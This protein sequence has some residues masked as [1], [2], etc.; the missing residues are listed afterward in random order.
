[1]TRQ[2]NVS[3]KA[4]AQVMGHLVKV[5]YFGALIANPG[6]RDLE[7]W[8]VMAFAAVFA[9]IGTTLSRSFLDRLSDKQFYY[10][11][12]RIILALGVVYIAQ[13]VWHLAAR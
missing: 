1:M 2:V 8:L 12:R 10:W 4:C 3:T 7:Q 11:T 5:V 13:G 6:G 9:V